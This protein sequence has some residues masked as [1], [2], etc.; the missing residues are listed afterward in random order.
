M[1]VT[2]IV[3]CE[4]GFWV[5][6]ALGLALRYPARMPRAGAAVLW[7]EPLLE[8]VLLVVTAVDLKNGAAPD[9]KHGLAAVYIGFTVTHG[10]YLVRWAD[11]HFAHRFADGPRPAKPPKYGMPRALHEWKMSARAIGAAAIAAALLQAAAW[12]VEDPGQATSLHAWQARM[13]LVAGVS[14]V[15]ALGYTVWPKREPAGGSPH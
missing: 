14:L 15:V 13:G 3:A 2:L 12:Y 8:L 5:L 11:G 6:L 1:L 7:C 4:I 9:W 10:H